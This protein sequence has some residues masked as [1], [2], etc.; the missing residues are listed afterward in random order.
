MKNAAIIAFAKTG[1]ITPEAG[2]HE[3]REVSFVI[4]PV[5]RDDFSA[6]QPVPATVEYPYH[7]DSIGNSII[8]SFNGTTSTYSANNLNQYSSI[9]TS[10][11]GLQT[12]DTYPQYDLDGNM[13]RHGEWTYA[14][15][16]DNRLVSIASDGISF[17]KQ[18]FQTTVRWRLT[19]IRYH[20]GKDLS[21][22][23][24]GAPCFSPGFML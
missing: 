14:Y 20:W 22:T 11:F 6:P 21:G 5:G 10:D 19:T 13:T 3:R 16:S 2:S 1:G 15:D 9:S 7:Y 17:G 24:H 4:K 18:S 8:A 12:L 23:L